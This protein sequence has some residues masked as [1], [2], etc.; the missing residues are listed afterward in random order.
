MLLEF[1]E[2]VSSFPFPNLYILLTFSFSF[3]FFKYYFMDSKEC[4]E[5]LEVRKVLAENYLKIHKNSDV[6]YFNLED[7][8]QEF[9]QRN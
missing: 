2:Y 9:S 8:S 5:E 3:L 4:I 1:F 6:D 7:E